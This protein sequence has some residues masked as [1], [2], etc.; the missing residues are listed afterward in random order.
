MTPENFNNIMSIKQVLNGSVRLSLSGQGLRVSH[1]D[2]VLCREVWDYV[3][4]G[5]LCAT[6]NPANLVRA[7]IKNI[8][9]P[10]IHEL[11]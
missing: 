10:K 6:P 9:K 8:S 7:V 3:S 1:I 4:Y 11:A 2:E 5:Q